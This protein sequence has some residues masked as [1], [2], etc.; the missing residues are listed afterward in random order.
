MF[1]HRQA[2][3]QRRQLTRTHELETQAPGLRLEG[4]V[5]AH[6]Q[7]VGAGE[8]LHQF[9]VA[10]RDARRVVGAVAGRK[11]AGI[12]LAEQVAAL[13]AAGFDQGFAQLVVP[14]AR[15]ACQAGL[16]L[17]HVDLGGSG[18][19]GAHDDHDAGHRRIR[20]L[21]RVLRRHALQRLGEQGLHAR[22]QAG[23]EAFARHID[24]AGDEAGE[25]I[26]AQ[27]QACALALAQAQDA[28]RRGV[29]LA[30]LDLEQLV[31]RVLIQDR[32]QRLGRMAVGQEAGACGDRGQLAPQQRDLRRIGVVGRRGEEAD[33][34][35]FA[36]HL[37]LGIEAFD[38]DVVEVAR[39]VHRGS[40]VGLGQQQHTRVARQRAHL[41]RQG[42]ERGRR[43]GRIAGHAQDAQARAGHAQRVLALDRD[44][45]VVALAEQGE[46]AFGQ[47]LQEGQVFGQIVGGHGRCVLAQGA[48]RV[49]DGLTHGLPVFDRRA[50]VTQD[51]Q[52]AVL[53]LADAL[54]IGAP[55]DLDMDQ[56]FE[57]AFGF[58]AMAGQADHAVL[59]V[60]AH[61]H[62][63]MHDQVHGQ[64]LAV[65]FHGDRIDQE[66]HVVVDDLDHGMGRL[67]AV[68]VQARVVDTQFGRATG[69]G[70]GEMPVRQRGAV[71]VGQRAF[72]QVVGRHLAVVLACEF[73]GLGGLLG[74]QLG[75]HAFGDL[76]DQAIRAQ[77]RGL[78]ITRW[79][80]RGHEWSP[81]R[82]RRCR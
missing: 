4:H 38:A 13:L 40:G 56:R 71:Q 65:D 64:T 16:E 43:R 78:G 19:T 74:G 30:G 62:H 35:P 70:A 79:R 53:Q 82:T 41:G 34:A 69:K 59:G 23:V 60:A 77:C 44:Q 33:E 45:V 66:G 25:G 63:R 18:A 68:F 55:I 75:A 73:G 28:H 17:A 10:H 20:Q 12:T 61:L 76:V 50:H 32:D 47:P 29:E 39:P 52:Q 42:G 37:A 14:A 67:P 26:A 1:E 46:V 9:D 49:D 7:R 27:E 72:G 5:Q 24:Q 3:R 57:A 51:A 81:F 80:R 36:Q 8:R 31:A 54:G 2:L 21:H 6:G 11:T 48:G 22:A 58:V 15:D